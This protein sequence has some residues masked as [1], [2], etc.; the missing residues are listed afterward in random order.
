M[1]QRNTLYHRPLQ[2]GNGI[3]A[4][5]ETH[6]FQ[7]EIQHRPPRAR[8][9]R[10]SHRQHDRTTRI[11]YHD[12]KNEKCFPQLESH[13]ENGIYPSLRNTKPTAR[14]I[15]PSH[16][17]ANATHEFDRCPTQHSLSGDD[18]PPEAGRIQAQ[19]RRVILP[20]ITHFTI[21]PVTEPEIG[22]IPFR[23][24]RE[25]F[26]RLLSSS[27]ALRTHPSSKTSHQRDSSRYGQRQT[28]EQTVTGRCRQWKNTGRT[29][30]YAHRRRQR[31]PS[32]SNGSHRNIGHPALRRAEKDGGAVRT[33]Y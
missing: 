30:E 11:L 12:R 3:Y 25:L 33:T 6:S 16:Y 14:N 8:P 18:R 22:R 20:A 10:R 2:T 23:P 7:R 28:N 1:V 24:Y 19:I 17:L 13:T 29:H 4:F 32:L 27:A 5:R 31:L 21:Y 15:A 9:D 26:Q